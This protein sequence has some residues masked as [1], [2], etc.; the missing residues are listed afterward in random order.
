MNGATDRAGGSRW[1]FVA[2]ILLGSFL[3][4]LVQPMVARMVLPRLGGAPNVWNSAMLVYQALLL[5]GYAYAH[6]LGRMPLRRQACIHLA[7][8]A[9]AALT[10]P[11]ALVD[12]P[13]TARGTEVL[14]VPALFVVS[15]GPVFLLVSAQAPLMQRWYAARPGVRL[16]WALY[17]ASNLGS[18]AGLMA[19]P[20]LVEPRLPITSQSAAWSMGYAAL[21]AL[22]LAAALARRQTGDAMASDASGDPASGDAQG[23]VPRSRM[24]MWLALS[25]VPSG[26]MLSTTS[27]LT[28]DLF[29]MPL[30]WVI[31][32][33]LYLLSM[34]FA[35]SDH[36]LATR[37]VTFA[38]PLVMLLAGGLA[39]VSRHSTTLS[40]AVFSVAL[41]FVICVALHGRL[42]DLRPP[43]SQLTR[44]YL[45]MALGG[46][47]GGAFTA[48]V[49]PLVFDWTWEHP[50]LV[51]AA[52][53]LLPLPRWFDWR[54]MP[55]L[56]PE[57]VR[58]AAGVVLAVI[59]F[60]AWLLVDLAAQAD[61]GP[62]RI[63]LTCAIGLLGLALVPW[64]AL[65]L[66]V[67]A[68]VMLVQGGADTIMTS[69]EGLRARS[70]FGVYTVRD[71]PDSELRILAHGTTLHGVQSTQ[72]ALRTTP[73]SYY[74][75][76]SGVAIA[77]S[78]APQLY[79]PR[80]RIGVLGLGVGTLACFHR[81]GQTWRF[82]EIDPVVLDYSLD[83]TFT[84]IKD[85]AP[86]AKV[87]IGDAR[88][89]LAKLPA[90]SLDMLA[91]DAFTS[92]AI[93]LHLITHEAIGDYLRVLSADGL[94]LV[95]ISN[96]F[97]ELEP[98]LAAQARARGLA[99]L[100]R[101]DVPPAGTQFT[102]SSWVAL[103]R[104][105]A[106]LDAL[107]RAAPEYEW[108][109]LQKAA[110]RPWTDDHASILPYIRWNNLLGTP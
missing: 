56:E 57:M 100:V 53:A 102:P 97:V 44:F 72:P 6:A 77:F 55:G 86:G 12:L 63:V 3:L 45:V 94:L 78:H 37:I 28:T 48:L 5:G 40:Q 39:M 43:V 13:P 24:A 50:V 103:A 107:R 2:T 41:L 64:R 19:Y 59:A 80:A 10:L 76:G 25:A 30:L 31:P 49:A 88:L 42:Y 18:F 8:L 101:D 104:D 93:P 35:F 16:P 54:R 15:V 82:F 11:I 83:G 38:A 99:A 27:H 73:I 60:L 79:G 81:P 62:Q 69:W 98:V 90:A 21:F 9:L 34:V 92:D 84:Y 89:E 108:K 87:L 33:G 17:A 105:P 51:L 66:G 68:V 47:L 46:A 32:L 4:F 26:L 36:R 85:C 58:F 29:A 70:Y 23:P 52:A 61:P 1:L 109:P 74:G 67:L 71:Y 7:L 106:R 65:Y 20:L 91:M 96:R 75:A 14:W 95:H 110:P 22:V